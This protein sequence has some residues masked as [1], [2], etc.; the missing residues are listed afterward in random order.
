ME[1]L[2]LLKG[3][4][5]NGKISKEEYL[6]QLDQLLADENI[7]QEEHDEAKAYDPSN[8]APLIYSQD[9]VN[10]IVKGRA[11][12][13]I[14][15]YLR[16]AGVED[17][18]DLADGEIEDKVVELVTAGAEADEKTPDEKELK[19]LKDR[20][21]KADQLE[22]TIDK[23]SVENGVYK[24]ASKYKPYDT[25]QVVRALTT[26][27]SDLLEYE[28]G[29]LVE[30]SVEKAVERVVKAEPNLFPDE[31]GKEKDDDTGGGDKKFKGGGPGGGGGSSNNDERKKKVNSAL[32]KMG[33]KKE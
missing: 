4:Y 1:E 11:L 33:Y 8:E 31:E 26:D 32:E 30:G 17:V 22:A 9:D 29:K 13:E 27:Y 15:K 14:R 25:K 7:T 28:D 6:K 3:K 12:R 21:A 5:E 10:R 24:V 18:D 16:N 20:A 23:L 19:R 2:K